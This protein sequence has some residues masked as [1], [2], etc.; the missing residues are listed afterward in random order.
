MLEF[1]YPAEDR[2]F[3]GALFITYK[4]FRLIMSHLNSGPLSQP[5]K[6]ITKKGQYSM[7]QG[8]KV[9]LCLLMY[10]NNKD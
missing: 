7:L 1:L 10:L 9:L 6:L 2:L 3:Q 5:S 4:S 8:K